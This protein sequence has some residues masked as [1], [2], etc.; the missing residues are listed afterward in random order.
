MKFYNYCRDEKNVKKAIFWEK[1][2]FKLK[3]EKEAH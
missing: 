3:T 2:G 1:I